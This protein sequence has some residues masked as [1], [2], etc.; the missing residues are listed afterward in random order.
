MFGVER[1]INKGCDCDGASRLVSY[2][3]KFIEILKGGYMNNA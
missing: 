2:N 1:R 3:S